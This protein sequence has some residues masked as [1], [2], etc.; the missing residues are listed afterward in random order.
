MIRKIINHRLRLVV[1]WIFL[2]FI[3]WISLLLFL[4][5]MTS[6][7]GISPARKTH[8]CGNIE[9]V[10]YD[11][12]CALICYDKIRHVFS[13]DKTLTNNCGIT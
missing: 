11:W 5:G 12:I 6:L 9:Y 2:L 10:P 3:C 8:L 1:S 7:R 4:H 13:F